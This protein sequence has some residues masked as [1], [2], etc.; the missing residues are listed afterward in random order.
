MIRWPLPSG[1]VLALGLLAVVL[2]L[3]YGGL[4]RPIVSGYAEYVNEISSLGGQ[5]QRFQRQAALEPGL[6]EALHRTDQR[7]HTK[8]HYLKGGKSSLASAELQQRLR[9]L[10]DKQGGQ[11]TSIQVLPSHNRSDGSNVSIRIHMRGTV[12]ELHR[13][14]YSME[15]QD[16]VLFLDNVFI[17]ATTARLPEK[18]RDHDAAGQLDIRFD[19]T[20][21]IW[22][23][24]T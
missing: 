22:K 19:L 16:P 2:L 5:L 23:E 17:V 12:G 14:F 21:Y 4:I 9:A 8:S 20:G 7:S 18:R 6:K 15:T 11:V 13:L 10:V 24:E 3:V 1:P